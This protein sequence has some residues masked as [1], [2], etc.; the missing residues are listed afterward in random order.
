MVSAKGQHVSK[1][2]VVLVK[3]GVRVRAGQWKHAR[4][5]ANVSEAIDSDA[6]EWI[7]LVNKPIVPID[8]TISAAANE[9]FIPFLEIP[10]VPSRRQS[11][12][13]NIRGE[14]GQR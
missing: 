10:I 4:G 13:G 1:R 9:S 5:E 7:T 11:L 2:G 8:A 12:R 14:R 6:C 3:G